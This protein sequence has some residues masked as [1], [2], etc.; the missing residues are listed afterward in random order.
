MKN[1]T[2]LSKVRSSHL[3]LVLFSLLISVLNTSGQ[4]CSVNAGIDDA[5]CINEQLFLEGSYTEPL[6][7]N[8]DLIWTQVEGPAAT[9]VDPLNLKTEVKNLIAGETY[10][11]RISTTCGDGAFTF[12]DVTYTVLE[13]SIAD[14][15]DDAIYCPGDAATL[16]A[17]SA[18]TNETGQWTGGGNGISIDDINNPNSSLT[19][20]GEN[21]GSA[22]LRWTI[23]NDN[24]CNTFDEVIITN[25]GGVSPV[26]AGAD[27][28]LSYCYSGFQS[29]QLQGSYAGSGIDGQIGTWT[30]IS[31]PNVP[32]INNP[33]ANSTLVTNLIEGSYVFR[34]TVNGPCISGY[35]EVTINVPAPTA[36]ITNASAE[37]DQV[38]CDISRTSTVL[39]GNSPLYINEDVEWVQTSGPQATIVSPNSPVTQITG[40]S[41]PNSYSFRYTISNPTL[42]PDGCSS[43]DVI[44]VSYLP[45]PPSLTIDSDDPII[46]D[47]GENTA[48][49]DF[50]A[51]GSGTSQFRIL[52]GP[53]SSGFS[54]PTG[55]TNA[56]TSP[57]T[58]TGLTVLGTYVV[59]MRRATTTGIDC[60]TQFD[61]ISIVISETTI[62]SNPGTAQI[63]NCNVTTTD[64]VGNDPGNLEGTWSQVSGPTE[65]ILTNIHSP[66]LTIENLQPNAV[67]VFRWLISGGPYCETSQQDVTVITAST[68]PT[69]VGAGND[70]AVCS[71][72][73][74]YLDAEYPTY[75]FELGTWSV[76]PSD[77]VTFSDVND[78]RAIVNGL[79]AFT[80]Y[81]FTWTISNGCGFSSNSTTVDVSGDEGP[82]ESHA[83]ADQCLNTGTTTI[84]L[85]GND[86]ASGTGQ[87]FKVS[88]PGTV[89]FTD[90]TQYD[91]EVS[92]TSDGNYQFEWV[93]SSGVGCSPTRDTMEVTIDAAVTTADAGADQE[94]CG[95]EVTLTG[96]IPTTG[97]PQW[98]QI[99]GNAGYTIQSP[100]SNSTLVTGLASGVYVFEYAISNGVCTSSDLVTIYVSEPPST[101]DAGD[102]KDLCGESSTTMNALAPADGTGLWSV[103]SGPNTPNIVNQNSP[104]SSVSNLITGTYTLQWTVY[105]GIF[106]PSSAD[107]VI[108][109][110]VR[111]ADAGADQSYCEEITAVNLTGTTASSGT[112]SQVSGPNTSTIT[113]TSGNTATTSDLIPGIYEF[114]YEITAT[115]C[116]T[117]DTMTVTLFEPPSTADAG[118]D[119]EVCNA[120]SFSLNATPP[121]SGTGT[122][123]VLSGPAG[124]SF[125]DV[126]TPNATFSNPGY[127]V[128]VF[129][130]TVANGDCSNADQVRYTN[131]QPPSTAVAGDDLDV[132]CDTIATMAANDPAVGVGEWTFVT[133]SGDGPNPVITSTILYNTTIT[134]L[135][136]QTD[137]NPETYT[138][139]WTISNGSEC[140]PTF[141][142]IN[143]TVYETPTPADA[144]PDQELCEQASVT[145]NAV[146]ATTGSG[147]WTQIS[148]SVTTESITTSS[149]PNTT[150]TGLITGET[151]V[152][153]WT[154]ETSFCSSSEQVTITNYQNPTPADASG[155]STSYCSIEPLELIGNNPAVGTGEWTQASGNL[156]SII[157]PTNPQTTAIGAKT[158]ETYE[159]QWTISNGTCSPSSDNVT[160][161]VN[162][163]P[164]QAL[165]GSDLEVCSPSTSATLSGNAP[166]GTSSGEWSVIASP[167]GSTHTF[168]DNTSPTAT[169]L[170]LSVGTYELQWRHYVGS[171]ETTDNMFITVYGATTTADAG[172][173]QELCNVSSTTLEGNVPNTSDGETGKWVRI[174]GPNNPTITNSS[175]NGTTVTGLTIGVYEFRWKILNGNCP[176]T[177]EDFV[178]ITNNPDANA[179]ADQ[180]GTATCGITSVTLNG[181]APYPGTGVWT[182]ESGTG[183]SFNDATSYNSAFSGTSGETYTLR[184]TLTGGDG[185]TCTSFDE[186]TVTFNEEP[187]V[188]PVSNQALCNTES[189]TAINFAGSL[190]GSGDVNSIIYRWTNDE[191]SID[192]AA[193][194]TGNIASF[195]AVNNG[196]TPVV[197]TI[198]VTPEFDN[199][200][201]VC[202]GDEESFTIT[203]NPTPSVTSIASKTI[204]NGVSVNY[205]IKSNVSETTFEWSRATVTGITDAGV[206]GQTT[207]PISETLTNTTNAPIDVEYI[208]TPTGPTGCVGDDFTLTVT[209][210]PTPDV[211]A[212]D[213][214]ICSNN[215][216]EVTL[217]SN[218]SGTTFYY[219]APTISGDPG[220]ITGGNARTSPGSTAPINDVLINTTA[221]N[222][223]ATYTIYPVYDGC[224]GSS[225]DVI[226]TVQPEPLVADQT[227]TVCSDEVLS[228]TLPLGTGVAA[229]TYDI[230]NIE[231][232]G[233]TASAGSPATGNSLSADVIENDAYTNT[234]DA[235]VD[236]VYTITPIAANGCSGQSFIVTATI[237]PEPDIANQ[238][239]TTCSGVAL[240]YNLQNLL[241]AGDMRSGST[242]S[243]SVSSS[244][245]TNVPAASDRTTAS[246]GNITDNYTNTTNSSVTITYTVTPT[247]G[248]G[249]TGDNFT[250]EVTVKPEP[251][252]NNQVEAEICSRSATG[253]TLGSNHVGTSVAPATFNITN[254]NSSGLSASAGSPAT[255]NGL[256]ANVISNDGWVNTT[257]S[258]V[259]VVYTVVPLSSDG[260]EGNSFTVT[261]P[262]KPEPVASDGS[263]VVC[264]GQTLDFSL[265]NQVTSLQTGATFTYTISSGDETNVPAASDRTVASDTNLTDSYTNNTN[266]PVDITYT[267]TPIAANNC[268]GQEFN[269][270]VTVNPEPQ[271]DN[272]GIQVFCNDDSETLNFSTQNTGGTTSYSWTNNNP[273]IGLG[274]SGSGN[275]TFTAANAGTSPISA[276]IEVTPTFENGGNS[277][278]GNPETFT[279]TVNPTGQ[280]NPISDQEFCNSASTTTVTFGTNNTGGTTTYAWTNNNIDIGLAA[281]GSGSTIPSFTATN[282]TAEPISGTIIVTPTFTN[283]GTGCAGATEQFVY[284]VYP[285]PVVSSESEVIV[286]SG[287]TLDYEITS[288]TPGTTFS[289]T[290]VNYIGTV[291]GLT[292]SGTSFTISDELT[293][294]GAADGKVTYTIVPTA[295]S[296][297]GPE[298]KLEVTVLNCNPKIGVAKQLV[299]TSYNEDGTADVLFNIRV[300]NYGNVVLDS[301]QV[302]EDLATAFSGNFEVL[303][304]S[305]TSFD[306]NTSFDG[307]AD[308]NLLSNSGTSNVLTVGTSTDIT[309]KVKILTAGSYT[310][311]VTASSPSSGGTIDDSQDG[312]DPD[313]GSSTLSENGDEEPGNN[314]EPTPVEIGSCT[315][316]ANVT[317]NTTCAN[318]AGV[319]E[320]TGSSAGTVTLNG[321]EKASPA[322]Y[323]GLQAGWYSAYYTTDANGCIVVANFEIINSNSDLAGSVTA[324]TNV[325]CN[326]GNDGAV[327]VVPTGGTSPYSFELNGS[328]VGDGV[329]TGLS[330]GEYGAKITDANGCTYTVSFDIDE[331]T[332]L[333]AQIV[334]ST[335]ERCFNAADGTATI[336]VTG[337]TSP[338]SYLWSN[339]QTT[340]TAVGL[341]DGSYTV[342]VTDAG[343][344]TVEDIPVTIGGANAV[345]AV[346]GSTTDLTCNGDNS[347]EIDIIVTGGT[348]PYSYVWSN[349]LSS[350]DISNLPAGDYS[351]VVTDANGCNVTSETFSLTQPAA[352]SLTAS[353]IVNTECNASVGEVTIEEASGTAGTF[354]VN[355]VNVTGSSATFTD[356][357]A[358]YYTATFVAT[359]TGCTAETSFNI[360]NSNSDLAGSVTAH[361]NV[362]CNGGNDGTV[363]VVP[364]GGTSP[365]SF[366]LNGSLVGDGVFTGLSAGEYGAKITDANGCTYTVSF[367]IDEPTELVAQIVSSTD[368]RCFN[369]ADGTA[370]IDVTGGTTPYSY[371]WSNGQTTATAVGLADG[372]YTV[373]VTDAGGCTVED[374]P[375]TIGG[376][377]AVLAVT[378]STTDLTCNGDNSGEI[379]IT[380]TGGIAPYSYVWSNG[381]SSEDISNLP[382]GDYSVVVTDANGCNVTSETFSLTQPAALSLTASNIVNT[383]CNASVGEVTIGEASGTAGTFTVNGVNVT[384]SSATFTDLPAGYY[385]AT[386]VA[387]GTGCT[388][389]TSFNIINS[390]S[391]LAGSVTAHT[392][393]SCN[394]GNDGAVTVVP[395]GGTSPYSFELNGS[396]VGD[397]VFTGLSAGEYGAKITD[398][399]GCTYTVSFDIDEPTEMVAQIVSSTDER[400]F[401]AADGTATIDVTGGTTPYSYLWSNGQTT[402]TAVGLA[403][404]SYTV[405][406]TDAGGCTVEDIPVTIGGANA[407]LAV[408]GSTTDL[409]CNGD[410]SGEIDITV[411]GG[412]APYSYVWSNGLSSE[413]ISNLP[414]GDYSVVVTDANGC[415]VTS[416]TFSLTQPAALSLTAS[417]IVNTECNASVGEVTIEEA[418][419]T[420]GTFTV[421]GVNV[422]GSSATFTDLPAGYYTATFVATGTGCTAE[423]SFNIINSNSDLAGSVTAH[424]NVSCNG[425]NDGAV[426]VVPT[427]G[428]SPYSFELNGS[429][430]GDGVFTGLSAGEYGAKIT[431]AN[432]C[433]YTVSFDIDEPTKLLAE[434]ISS[435]D[436]ICNGATNGSATVNATGGT[437]PYTYVWDDGSS[438]TTATATGLA[439][440]TYMVT[441][442]DANG[443]TTSTSVSI[444][445]PAN[446]LA[447]S[448]ANVENP[449]CY[450]ANDGVIDITVEGGTS[451][452]SYV[453]SNGQATQDAT[454]LVEGDY[455]VK[456][457]DSLGCTIVGGPY[458][459]SSPGT[460]TV[461]A[462]KDTT[463]CS[464]EVI[465]LEGSSNVDVVWTTSGTGTFDDATLLHAE[466]T[467][468]EADI[469]D[470]Q[471]QL[472]LTTTSGGSCDDV[473]DQ[474]VLTIWKQATAYAGIDAVSATGEPYQVLD[475][476]AANYSSIN[477]T[478]NGLGDLSG[479]STLS[480]VYTPG[481]GE[482]GIISL[483]LEA[484]PEG[485]DVCLS[486]KDT[487]TISIG[488]EP[489]IIVEKRTVQVILNDDG[490]T[491]ITFEFNL[492]NTGNVDLNEIGLIDDLSTTFPGTCNIN[493]LSKTSDNFNVNENFDGITDTQILDAGNTLDVLS[494]KAVL[495]TVRISGCDQSQTSFTN[496]AIAEG[497]SAGNVTVTHTDLSY[498]SIEED[499]AIGLAKQLVTSVAN[500]DG[501]YSL[502]FN[503]RVRNYGTVSLRDITVEDDLDDV[504]GTGNYVVETITSEY[505]AVNVNYTGG[506]GENLLSD[507]N[508]LE[509]SETGAI[510]L[511][512]KV[513][514]AGSYSNQAKVLGISPR[515]TEVTDLSHAGTNPDPD[516]DGDPTNNNETTNIELEECTASLNCPDLVSYTRQVS[517]GECGYIVVGQEFDATTTGDCELASL[518]HDYE[519]WNSSS[520][521]GAKLPVGTTTINWTAEFASGNTLH[522]QEMITVEDNEAPEFINCPTDVT[523]NVALFADACQTG[524]IWSIPVANDN[525]SPVEVSQIAGPAQG[526]LLE[527]GFYT[528]TYQAEDEAGN[529]ETCSFNINVI[530]TEDPVVVCQSN[531]IMDADAGACSWK[532]PNGSLS[533]LLASSNCEAE[534]RWRV[535]GPDGTHT[536]G[537]DDVS[538]FEFDLGTSTVYYTI[539]ESASGQDWDCNFTVTVED[540]EAP[541]IEC[542][543]TME[544][545]AN[546]GECSAVVDLIAPTSTD[547]C[548]SGLDVFFKIFGPDNSITDDYNYTKVNSYEFENGISHIEWKVVDKA[549]NQ[550]S[551]WQNIWVSPDID[552][553]IPDAGENAAICNTD[554]FTTE[555]TAP[556]HSNV[557]WT[558][559]GTGTFAHASQAITMYTP[560]QN[561]IND[562]SVILTITSSTDCTSSSDQM[563]L[564]LSQPPQVAA[565]ADQSICET[566]LVQLNGSII[567]SSA[568]VVWSTSGTGTFSESSAFNP[569][570][571]PSAEDIEAGQVNLTFR[572]V[573]GSTCASH[574]D[575]VTVFI[576]RLPVVSAGDDAWS[577]QEESFQ[578]SGAS[579]E[580]AETILWTTSGSGSF[581][582]KT[583]ENPVYTPSESDIA[584]GGAVLTVTGTPAGLCSVVSD[585][586]TLNISP[587][588]TVDAGENTHTCYNTEIKITGASAS[589]YATLD[590]TTTGLGTLQDAETLNP[591]Y[592]PA[593]DETGVIKLTLTITSGPGCSAETMTDSMELEILP[594]LIVDIGDDET[595]F[596]NTTI[597]LSAEVFNGTDSYFYQWEPGSSVIDQSSNTTETIQLIGTTTFEVLVIDANTGCTAYDD[598][599]VYV[600]DQAE[601][602]VE[603]YRGF[604][605]NGDGTNDTWTIKGIEKFPLNKVVIFNRWGDKVRELY[606][607]NN[608][609]VVWDGT[610][611]E[612]KEL[613]DGTYYYIVNLLN[614][615]EFTGWVHIRSDR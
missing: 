12:Q 418:S 193:S 128:Y 537:E 358:G 184:W 139:R 381:L 248:Q 166:E 54:F 609:S 18:G 416:E 296:C 599:T 252:V 185:L 264:S 459:L 194:G 491:D 604:S 535:V 272:P 213:K 8:A 479:A 235:P 464:S 436:V 24:G 600:E 190:S 404:G 370:T 10:T 52:S 488:E 146:P 200:G 163:L 551:C 505:F 563:M 302:V 355:G 391:D 544:V 72:T 493:V 550:S 585:E 6:Q 415:N 615:E 547:N 154:T 327:T 263:I 420:A 569:V 144:G 115:G 462:G 392:N 259:D 140:T 490:S 363:T 89:I 98:T 202:Y 70:Q 198:T 538:G 141:D 330:A 127:G 523:Y 562:G 426:T 557:T 450:D 132:T 549:G 343:G 540:S 68:E 467:P 222:Q 241:P 509:P 371:L 442:T 526:E 519:L 84:Q 498:I 608:T 165:A 435:N 311:Q 581:D 23:S 606:N 282:N 471:V 582:D 215:Q 378:G 40:L 62:A 80:S 47:C 441:V 610:N 25:R 348:A 173:D 325:S 244:D 265:L 51:G 504:F 136:P 236:V 331:P 361:T 460:Y 575:V 183:G 365:Y 495:L 437:T 41:S 30:I 383:E 73:P 522:C 372:S 138:F 157:D 494:K 444:S 239:T 112:W 349:G 401:N 64:L 554:V 351:V 366:E 299:N 527:V 556:A 13:A 319:V 513:L 541:V 503:I 278:T 399:N 412:T 455:S 121:V 256:S 288:E 603:F 386:F 587:A 11:F 468:S 574:E 335:D 611:D 594:P 242:F 465:A 536:T 486:A 390:N 438:Q 316:T 396:L 290:A 267:V 125:D 109:T 400:C 293:N 197:A 155:T 499:P 79:D 164:S 91:T 247:S 560:S 156:L 270:T 502:S 477:W 16:S 590:W 345:L 67:Y 328:L 74:V 279:I 153:E 377:N 324:H 338:Y 107:T 150:V 39:N 339:G 428:T 483:I 216:A 292:P 9:I 2:L 380:V 182:I 394:G 56:G 409:T 508:Y 94:I 277:C 336:D 50:T 238:T 201:V 92:V 261:V 500:G 224:V 524:A 271:V 232:N 240:D 34:W 102:D 77:G 162:D 186:M 274:A 147:T 61:Q 46:N 553:L 548:S 130:W 14:A 71:N 87:W 301:I 485:G 424:T 251:V 189:T 86:P 223:T 159:F 607:Y 496:E 298:F 177:S 258:D 458:S 565:G 612:G 588:S 237:N 126:N 294:A 413:D 407:V 484:L 135:G 122:W 44:T 314:N 313:D 169:I 414:A 481:N 337:G 42:G 598:M 76:T 58:I 431:D 174:S 81:T 443:C 273:S 142:E 433:T 473:S 384:G 262:V 230:T 228:F 520:L 567:S 178:T 285:T 487:M 21:S 446:A 555:A 66:V 362:S 38:F 209:V 208:I 447:I 151:Y 229:D 134:N 591:T 346:T 421:N 275:L 579:L 245:E 114:E 221:T 59:E 171:C 347:G 430:V 63:L 320:L 217:S 204:C 411:T 543:P 344:C 286:C 445:E 260:C 466:Y 429:L 281:S 176:T 398:A 96:N 218:V 145:L 133:K 187:T 113:S 489:E 105:G 188:N 111:E 440:D 7:T 246:V 379:D 283:G 65:I 474:M 212:S 439:A 341:A 329:F 323:S 360:I 405:T 295:N 367:D 317:Q 419:G 529:I 506:T 118:T 597:S 353:N 614:V 376:A 475:A 322:I 33:N 307:D 300:Q 297:P 312:S 199:S 368:E 27:Q 123:S 161:S 592:V 268:L 457:T 427:G 423:T 573:S 449:S 103:I 507:N 510:Q 170:N 453:W 119:F 571:T 570:Y 461:D 342:T 385:T 32:T 359:G 29:T 280:V 26:S 545:T 22:T 568:S 577:C 306:V 410:N 387:T 106:C 321:V 593:D 284:T 120:A 211:S 104:I 207:D 3:C 492:E 266:S 546:A 525:C 255:G 149:N 152:F 19:I 576:N 116:S 561:D 532:S 354:T 564:I 20:S 117:A 375:V 558:S 233:L 393:V 516:A 364:T 101:A 356:L 422:T 137:G 253:V 452:Y 417:N 456:I 110:V 220:N 99:S 17:N 305:S 357:P 55:W 129:Q 580:Y 175:D 310:N 605:P 463:I 249:C 254:I 521:A 434:I 533:P 397:G 480:P 534:V 402:A 388:A 234:T 181:N 602:I 334:S 82:I 85:D 332:E 37:A 100:N 584:N 318:A 530:D 205:D 28:D 578:L 243:Y 15:G 31:G 350:E 5:I 352:L 303:E 225:L 291:T 470:G 451:P 315:L 167:S 226:V 287:E 395:T 517:A 231:L 168:D 326:G 227:L 425:G 90:D 35:D 515:G 206:T 596:S 559:T 518:T 83:G 382:A 566:E 333:V 191:T 97:T 250:L 340:A 497:T 289:W 542:Q 95:N 219:D 389:E 160:I 172:T 148:P 369:A 373:T 57:L 4:N 78:P 214:I 308:Q 210:N 1:F 36:D 60:S 203:V 75:V 482:T 69:A 403:D 531:I 304:L 131:Y 93:I 613:V 195:A 257:G 48:T 406:V 179:G 432:G 472:T 124:G 512:I 448:T 478:H 469:S 143:I 269:I 528:I 196:T 583:A 589:N 601:S 43:S 309:L 501:T 374:I 552:A 45:N 595:I 408:T 53:A 476:E 514:S 572:G 158:G 454:N 88:G 539:T 108:I 586:M 276:T 49:I 180:T 192:L 511:S